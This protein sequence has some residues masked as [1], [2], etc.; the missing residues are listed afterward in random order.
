MELGS[1]RRV[2]KQSVVDGPLGIR[3]RVTVPSRNQAK[4]EPNMFEMGISGQDP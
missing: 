1:E 2:A 3:R 4:I